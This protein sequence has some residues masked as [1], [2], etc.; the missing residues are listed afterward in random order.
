MSSHF[1]CNHKQNMLPY[2]CK[3]NKN[4]L[5]FEKLVISIHMSSALF[6][7]AH[8][9]GSH[10]LELRL[11]ILAFTV[12]AVLCGSLS[13]RLFP[14]ISL[15]LF[16]CLLSV[17][18]ACAPF[19]MGAHGWVAKICQPCIWEKSPCRSWLPIVEA[20]GCRRHPT[21]FCDAVVNFSYSFHPSPSFAFPLV[22]SSP[23]VFYYNFPQTFSHRSVN[24]RSSFS[25]SLSLT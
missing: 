17:M 4:S 22:Q 2:P 24:R 15:P 1:Q 20:P 9:P 10:V 16:H 14:V 11:R 19:C 13:T 6:L 3:K 21:S 8:A 18:A 23:E 25:Q 7:H 12:S 5:Q